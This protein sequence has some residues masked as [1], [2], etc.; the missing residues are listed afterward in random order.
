VRHR[1]SRGGDRKLNAALHII[2]ICQVRHGA[3]GRDY[4][5]RKLDQGKTRREAL[6]CLKRRLSDAVFKRLCAD[7][8]RRIL[9]AA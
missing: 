3:E 6:R 9:A 4:F 8:D 2:A 5:Q 1:L 7:S